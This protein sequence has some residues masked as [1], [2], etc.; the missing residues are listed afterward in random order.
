MPRVRGVF[1]G[2]PVPDFSLGYRVRGYVELRVAAG[3]TRIELPRAVNYELPLK[4]PETEAG[5]A[6]AEVQ[7]SF[8]GDS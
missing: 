2:H 3:T 1:G 7:R 4:R 8:R 5:K 6:T